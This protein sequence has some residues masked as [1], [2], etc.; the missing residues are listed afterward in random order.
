MTLSSA[1]LLHNSVD[2][3]QS[4]DSDQDFD[5]EVDSDLEY[6]ITGQ[7]IDSDL[8][9]EVTSQDFDQDI[10]SDFDHSLD[11]DLD[12]SVDNEMTGQDLSDHGLDHD[13]ISSDPTDLNEISHPE[14]T[15][16]EKKGKQDEF[17][18]YNSNTPLS[19]VF[20]LYLLWSGTIGLIFYEFLEEKLLWF[21]IL[22]VFPLAIVKLISKFWVRFAKNSLYKVNVGND[23]I[24]RISTV[25]IDVT[26]NGGVISIKNNSSIQQLGVRSLF[27]LSYFYQ[28]EK[29]YICAFRQNIYYVDIDPKYVGIQDSKWSIPE[30]NM[31]IYSSRNSGAISYQEDSSSD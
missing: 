10:D 2:A 29:V 21:A 4:I 23:L 13:D 1:N 19:L 26:K 27:P 3:D 6:E 22:L 12:N 17:V 5:T 16:Q 25:K 20:S 24:G 11:H 28:G 9:H 14:A 8:D 7:D 15:F 18:N 30:S 31:E